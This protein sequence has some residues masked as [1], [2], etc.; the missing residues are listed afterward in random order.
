MLPV[1]DKGQSKRSSGS[2]SMTS[3]E[4][5]EERELFDLRHAHPALHS[6]G[7]DPLEIFSWNIHADEIDQALGCNN[8]S[9]TKPASRI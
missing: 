7:R 4:T 6:A 9:S 8:P 2:S 1:T 5:G 3:I